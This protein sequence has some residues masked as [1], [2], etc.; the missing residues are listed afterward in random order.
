MA[1]SSPTLEIDSGELGRKAAQLWLDLDP[2]LQPG[3]AILAPTHEMRAEINAAVRH[4]LEDEGV[5]HAPELEIERYVNLHL[6]RS[7]K[8]DITNYREGH[9][10][11]SPSP[12]RQ[13]W[14]G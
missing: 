11:N 10:Q 9:G 4:G 12:Q 13:A 5:L 8:G 1:R 6:T 2:D 3:T 14:P 7:Q